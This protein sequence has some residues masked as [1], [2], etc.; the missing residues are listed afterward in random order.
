MIEDVEL[1]HWTS[2][3][4]RLHAAGHLFCTTGYLLFTARR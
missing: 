1:R 2:E 3:I 4:E